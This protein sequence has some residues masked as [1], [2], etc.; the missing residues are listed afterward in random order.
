MK[1]VLLLLALLA[2]LIIIW[3][4]PRLESWLA[5]PNPDPP[6]PRSPGSSVMVT[7]TMCYTT[8]PLQRDEVAKWLLPIPLPAEASDIQYAEYSEGIA[9]EAYATF[10]APSQT[11]LDYAKAILQEDNQRN[12]NR[13]VSLDLTPVGRESPSAESSDPSGHTV[14]PIRTTT[15]PAPGSSHSPSRPAWKAARVAVTVR[16]SGWMCNVARST[17]C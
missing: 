6:M 7:K 15:P 17:T 1:R 10:H 3:L 16:R 14:A 13:L 11:C 9:Y 5:Q 4:E 2:L 12:P 8:R